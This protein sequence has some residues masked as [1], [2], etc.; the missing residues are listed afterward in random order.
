MT[1]N[2]PTPPKHLT[3]STRKW[4]SSVVSEFELEG[5]HLKILTLSAESW[6][7]GQQARRALQKHGIVYEDRFGQPKARPEIAIERDSRTG[8]AR[9]LRELALDVDPPTESR[10]PSVAGRGGLLLK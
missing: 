10:P 6:D 9:M 4:W 7:R 5:H 8:F 1:K 3:S 2:T